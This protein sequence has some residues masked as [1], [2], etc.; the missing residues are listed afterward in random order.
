MQFDGRTKGEVSV[1]AKLI[2]ADGAEVDLGV[3]S[4]AGPW[5]KVLLWK[6][7]QRGRKKCRQE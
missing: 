4:Y 6:I 7:L 2:K 5:Y 1:S 3:I